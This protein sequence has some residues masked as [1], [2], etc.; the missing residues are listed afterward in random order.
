MNISEYFKD[1]ITKNNILKFIKEVQKRCGNEI[2]LNYYKSLFGNSYT[3]W[4]TRKDWEMTNIDFNSYIDKMMEKYFED[5]NL[6]DIT[7]TYD[8]EKTKQY[9][10]SRGE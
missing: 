1:I 2:Y 8:E 10:L 3:I 4:H 7:F 9:E 5:K 6:F